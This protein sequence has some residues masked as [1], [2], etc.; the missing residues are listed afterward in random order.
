MKSFGRRWHTKVFTIA[1]GPLPGTGEHI[2]TLD[3]AGKQ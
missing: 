1:D 3:I 2:Q